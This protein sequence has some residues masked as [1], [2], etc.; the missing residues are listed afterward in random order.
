AI[1]ELDIADL[2]T[3]ISKLGETESDVKT[4]Y[5]SLLSG[6]QKHLTA[7]NRQLSR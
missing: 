5:E 4:V 1:E 6:S 2:K 3:D 7:F